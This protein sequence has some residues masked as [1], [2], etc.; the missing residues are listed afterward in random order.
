MSAPSTSKF[1]YLLVDAALAGFDDRPDLCPERDTTLWLVPL[2]TGTAAWSGPVLIDIVAAE[3][4]GALDQAMAVVNANSPQ[5]HLSI[6]DTVLQL[7]ALAAHLRRFTFIRNHE[8]QQFSLRFADCLVLAV[9][10][11]VL[12]AGQWSTV[13]APLMR[14]SVHRRDGT[15]SALVGADPAAAAVSAPLQL[16]ADQTLQLRE[17]FAPDRMINYLRGAAHGDIPGTQAEQHRW[18]S[19]AY[20]V[21]QAS[22]SREEIVWRWLTEAAFETR[23]EVLSD[24]ELISALGGQDTAAVRAALRMMV[25]RSGA[26][27]RPLSPR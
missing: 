18:A 14:W 20:A 17:L 6:I 21:W 26:C 8:Q 15:L 9:L 22:R 16:T 10:P 25:M 3:K 12:S 11:A 1:S 4:A 2:Y 23:G 19:A 7:N 24:S 13:S 27:G 5:L